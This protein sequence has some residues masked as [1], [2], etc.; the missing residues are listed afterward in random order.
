MK[1]ILL[2]CSDSSTVINFR[3]EL[4]S[5]LVSKHFNVSIII[6]D[7]NR[8]DEIKNLGVEVHHIPFN[9]R[10][11]NP[12][13]TLSLL[14]KIKKTIKNINP[15]LVFTFQIKPNIIGAI[16]AHK[17]KI[18]KI[19]CMIEGLGDPFQ[20]KNSRGY[21]LRKVVV[22]LYKKSLKHVTN[23]FVLNKTDYEEVCFWKMIPPERIITIPG[24]GIDTSKYVADY[25]IPFE[26]KVLNLSRLI[27]NKGIIDYCEIARRVRNVRPDISFY[28]FGAESQIKTKDINDYINDGSII[29]GGYINDPI[30]LM[31]SS[32]LI[33]SCSYREGFP[34]VILEAMSLGKV[35]IASNV[36]GNKDAI[37]DG[38]T[39]FLVDSH[40]INAFAERIIQT[41]DDEKSLIKLGKAAR[42]KCEKCYDSSIIN[43]LIFNI[44]SR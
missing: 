13:S 34:R 15:D 29:Y 28:L 17:A 4:I 44:I 33:V 1:K 7:E 6:G 9:N 21:L 16:A 11:I 42:N 36:P 26:K 40:N 39:G 32:R 35:V 24:I 25:T 27:I 37:V 10:S 30:D 38:E 43:S 8:I 5:F 31:K 20:P 14:H 19:Y 12:F 23:L 41:I 18:K 22:F 2:I 3:R